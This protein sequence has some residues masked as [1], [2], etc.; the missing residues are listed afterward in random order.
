MSGWAGVET[1]AQIMDAFTPAHRNDTSSCP[2]QLTNLIVVALNPLF[3]ILWRET[4]WGR[5]QWFDLYNFQCCCYYNLLVLMDRSFLFCSKAKS[6]TMTLPFSL[7]SS[8]ISI[9]NAGQTIKDK[10]FGIIHHS[11]KNRCTL[12]FIE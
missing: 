6:E 8:M 12:T 11:V 5:S 1:L 4:I 2:C 3:G 7:P 9:Y 10:V